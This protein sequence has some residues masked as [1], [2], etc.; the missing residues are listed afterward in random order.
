MGGSAAKVA[1]PRALR[2]KG[3][4]TRVDKELLPAHRQRER[5]GVGVAVGR[6][7]LITNRTRIGN[8][9][10]VVEYRDMVTIVRKTL[11]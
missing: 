1:A 2:V 5:Q 9:S 11:A 8:Q 4:G 3:V 6:D 7:R 10:D